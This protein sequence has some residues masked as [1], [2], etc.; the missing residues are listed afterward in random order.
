MP[1]GRVIGG[2]TSA[3]RGVTVGQAGSD[4]HVPTL[5][6]AAEDYGLDEKLR[7][8]EEE[9]AALEENSRKIRE[10]VD[11]LMSAEEG[12][13][14]KQ[15]ELVKKLLSNAEKI[16][17]RVKQ[18]RAEV[19]AIKIESRERADSRISVKDKIYA[20]TTLRIKE[21]AVLINELGRGPLTARLSRGKIVLTAG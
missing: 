18:L 9:I 3:L 4:A 20:E 13:S 21:T 8:Q 14:S 11:P 7:P 15:K 16:E 1:A 19:E 10:T 12:L 6:V 17:M 5:I 2:E